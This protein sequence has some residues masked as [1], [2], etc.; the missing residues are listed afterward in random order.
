MLVDGT[1]RARTAGT[2]GGHS[3]SSK[4]GGKSSILTGGGRGAGDDAEGS[5]WQGPGCDLQGEADAEAD[6]E[7]SRCRQAADTEKVDGSKGEMHGSAKRETQVSSTANGRL[8][9]A[10]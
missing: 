10:L 5:G 9:A 2:N 1:A 7:G 6:A 4:V 3:S 8:L